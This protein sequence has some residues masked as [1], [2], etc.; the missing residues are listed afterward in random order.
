MVI[1]TMS[2]QEKND[3]TELKVEGYLATIH[4]IATCHLSNGKSLTGPA[5]GITPK[6]REY[7]Q[8]LRE[9]ERKTNFSA[10]MGLLVTSKPRTL[11]LLMQ[12]DST[13]PTEH[14]HEPTTSIPRIFISHATEDKEIAKILKER[15]VQTAHPFPIS[16]FVSSDNG[17]DCG[18]NPTKAIKNAAVASDVMISL[19]TPCSILK[20]WIL[21][22]AGCAWGRGITVLPIYFGGLTP[23]QLPGPIQANFQAKKAEDP[24]EISNML[25]ALGET[26]GIHFALD[27]GSL[28][29]EFQKA[30][31]ANPARDGNAGLRDTTQPIANDGGKIRS[32]P[33]R[34]ELEWL[35]LFLKLGTNSMKMLAILY[36]NQSEP[37]SLPDDSCVRKLVHTGF[38][39]QPPYCGPE[40]YELTPD[41]LSFLNLH[42]DIGSALIR[43]LR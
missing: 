29:A 10:D 2:Q 13:M 28:A 14:H 11:D 20:P 12:K 42:A 43:I 40:E 23:S 5:W 34:S 27:C 39:Y 31:G 24:N 3:A 22:E 38:I 9:E 21:F 30:T 19:L 18:A 26:T 7:L 25:R 1:A 36:R 15:L 6:G 33:T 41:F 16:V 32:C 8:Q 17:I 4:D 37:Q 35:N